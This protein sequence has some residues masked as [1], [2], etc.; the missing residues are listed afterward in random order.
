MRSRWNPWKFARN[1][2]ILGACILLIYLGADLLGYAIDAEIA[3][4]DA[5]AIEWLNDLPVETRYE[6]IN[7]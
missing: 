6:Y 1:L 4:Q 5:Q 3:R 7:N 2:C